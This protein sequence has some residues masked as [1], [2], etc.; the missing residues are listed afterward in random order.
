[1]TE[2]RDRELSELN[3]KVAGAVTIGTV[4]QVDPKLARYRVKAGDIESDWIPMAQRRSGKTRV[5]EALDVG[6]QVV[7]AAPSGDLSQ[8]VIIGSIPTEEREAGDA[9]KHHRT[10][11]PDGTVVEYDDE[12][13]TYNLTVPKGGGKVNVK[14]GGHVAVDGAK[15]VAVHSAQHV[16]VDGRQLTT[17][18]GGGATMALSDDGVDIFGGTINIRSLSDIR[19]ESPGLFHNGKNIGVTHVHGGIVRGGA[20]TDGPH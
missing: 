9:A 12:A 3:R 14:S 19:I 5:Y 17:V 8:G 18:R 1:M 13:N 7:I 2:R 20:D 11:Y 16:D 6:E 10:I 15:Q 4:S